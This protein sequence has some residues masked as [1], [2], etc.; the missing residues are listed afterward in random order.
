MQVLRV[1]GTGAHHHR[2]PPPRSAAVIHRADLP[3]V[4]GDGRSRAVSSWRHP[5]LA[6]DRHRRDPG[7]ATQ[8]CRTGLDAAAL[9]LGPGLG[10]LVGDV[11]HHDRRRHG[12]RQP[13]LRLFFLLDD[14][15][16]FH[17]RRCRAR[18]DLADDRACAVRLQPGRRPSRRGSE[19]RAMVGA[20]RLALC[21][22][23]A[24]SPFGGGRRACRAHGTPAWT[25]PRTSIRPSSGSWSPGPS[26]MPRSASSCS[27]SAWRKL[28]RPADPGA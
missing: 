9:C 3:L 1:A 23:G 27:S 12:I 19:R 6:L 11:H 7:E 13:G 8:G 17:R 14:P 22:A 25:R 18:R 20:M 5:L 26:S 10:R 2:R 16:R 4:A 15:Q 24:C 28:C 21:V